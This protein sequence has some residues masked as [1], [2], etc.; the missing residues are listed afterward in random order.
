[1]PTYTKRIKRQSLANN[2]EVLAIEDVVEAM[3]R[4]SKMLKELRMDASNIAGVIAAI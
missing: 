1:M 3:R 4:Y 2:N